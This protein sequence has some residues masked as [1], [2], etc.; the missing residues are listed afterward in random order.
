[1]RF[2]DFQ[3]VNFETPV[4]DISYFFYSNASKTDLDNHQHYLTLYYNTFSDT[5]KILGSDVT[6]L[7][8][9]DIFMDHWR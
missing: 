5:V 8:P 1:M 7:Y 9:L 4:Y 6:K 2:L 3:V